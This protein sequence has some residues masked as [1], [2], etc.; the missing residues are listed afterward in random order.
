MVMEVYKGIKGALNYKD[1]KM[2]DSLRAAIQK[3]IEQDPSFAK[4]FVPASTRE[5]LRL[6]HNEYC[7]EDAVITEEY[8]NPKKEQGESSFSEEKKDV[9]GDSKNPADDYEGVN[10]KTDSS[11][12]MN[13][14]DEFDDEIE[15][16]FEAD[17]L[18]TGNRIKRDYVID[19]GYVENAIKEGSDEGRTDFGE[20]TSAQQAFEIKKPIDTGSPFT[21]DEK[22]QAKKKEE[23]FNP[24]FN[25]MDNGKKRKQTTR[26]AK[27]IV[28]AVCT[29]AE[30]GFVWYAT[31]DINEG[32]LAEYQMTGEIDLNILLTLEGNQKATVQTFFQNMC[33]Q[34]E[35]LAKIDK[36][37]QEELGDALA[38]VLLEKG[39]AP[40]PMQ[41]LILVSVQVFVLGKGL[42]LMAHKAQTSSVLNQLR[43]MQQGGTENQY[44]RGKDN[45]PQNEAPSQSAPQPQA[46]QEAPSATV[47]N[48]DDF[49]D[50]DGGNSNFVEKGLSILDSQK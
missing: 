11:G 40:T 3:K 8:V 14:I 4:Q 25:D 21:T 30:R 6:L 48:D 45:V 37:S 50:G 35:Q 26:M 41:N 2:A 9:S 18:K 12:Q 13:F 46:A 36:E 38:E 32:K 16:S 39:I 42:Q 34:A 33:V 22:G 10:V 5:E 7:T 23:P 44:A 28:K 20:P 31:K 24:S 49:F 47:V 15:D 27:T 1:K 19:D 43:A 17:P 29:L